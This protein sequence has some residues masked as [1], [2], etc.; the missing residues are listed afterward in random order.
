[1]KNKL[2]VF[3]IDGLGDVSI[4]HYDSKTPLQL[5]NTPHLDS[6]AK[7]G[8]NGLLDPV[9]P[10]L[11]CGSDTAHL[12]ILGYDPR[13]YYEG[14]GAFESMGAGLDMIPGDIAFKSN[15]AYLD[16]DSGIVVSRKA[17][18]NFEGLGPILCKAL[19][20]IKLPSFPE[21]SVAVKY[22]I[23]HR[24]GVRVRGPGLSS[25]ITGTD[26]LKDNKKLVYCEPTVDDEAS[27]MTSKLTNELSTVLTEALKQHPINQERNKQGKN[28][29]NCV[30]LRG[31]GSCID[32]PNIQEKHGLKS[33]LI[34]PT[35]IIAGIGMTVGMDLIHVPGATGDYGTDFDAK[36]KACINNIQS[37]IYDFGFCHLKAVDDA[38]HDHDVEKK[39]Y[40]LEKIDNMI[41]SVISSLRNS[42]DTNYT[43]IVTGDHTTPALYGDHSCEPVPFAISS[44][45]EGDSVQSFNEI[46]AAQGALGRFCGE[47]VMS[48]AKTF[49]NK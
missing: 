16:E 5:A 14:R 47:Q 45:K 19:D 43:I 49:M 46:D 23:E 42:L 17:D 34:A 3:L 7:T 37:D 41:G 8:L 22:A 44:L 9:E 2:L 24:C 21:H 40:Y 30:L 20:G 11:A 25:S 26:P 12:S 18:R 35:C 27:K 28:P 38:G 32:V 1:M 36:A 15:F 29:I 6:L 39:I 4:S 48:L 13:I 33:F 31:C 10:G